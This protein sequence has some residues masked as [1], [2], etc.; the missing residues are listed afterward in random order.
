MQPSFNLIDQP[1]IPVI[2]QDGSASELGLRDLLLEARAIREIGGESPLVIASIYRLLLALLHRI[3]NGPADSRAWHRLWQEGWDAAAIVDYLERWHERFDL[4]HPEQPFYQ[5]ADPRMEPRSVTAMIHEAASGNNAT[6]FDHHVDDLPIS[7]TPAEAA[8]RLLAVVNYGLSGPCNPQMKLYFTGGPCVDGILFLALGDTLHETLTLNLL[9]YPTDEAM[10]HTAQDRPVWEADDPLL[11]ERD[12][13]LGYLDYLTWLNRRVLLLPQV[14]G[15]QVVVQQMTMSPALVLNNSVLDPMMHY[16][17]DEKRG[18]RPLSF[19]EARSLWRDS[20]ALFRLH[21][22]EHRPPQVLGWLARLDLSG[23]LERHRSYRLQALGLLNDKAKMVFFRHERLPL[24]T[25]YLRQQELV[26]DLATAL[27]MAEGTANQLWGATATLAKL[28]VAPAEDQEAHRDDWRPLLESWG[29]G[30]IYWAQL[31]TPFRLTMEALPGD[32]TAALGEWRQRLLN[33]AWSA[34]NHVADSL[35]NT[36]RSL[37]A[38]VQ[39]QGQLAAGLA[40]TL[41]A[42]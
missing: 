19:S 11:P 36:P 16:F 12:T 23:Y 34:F 40:K 10:P 24:P 21:S 42:V 38:W 5:M 25:D 2:R 41:P 29:V 17:R 6:L 7:L 22:S 39:A 28:L 20:A 3:H 9:P 27:A 14:E 8:R 30:R 26:E 4:F 13:P 33:A 18:P 1:W 37:R 15:G 35:D 31:E 32:R